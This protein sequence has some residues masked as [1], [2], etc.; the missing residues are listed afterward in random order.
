M[1]RVLG[2]ISALALTACSTVRVEENRIETVVLDASETV[3][4][5]GRRHA[6][7]YNTEIDLVECVSNGLARGGPLVVSERELT[8][9]LYPWLEPRIAPVKIE[10]MLHMMNRP[11][12]KEQ[13]QALN[14][15]YL[16]WVDGST[17]TTDQ[18]GSMSC[19]IAPGFA[20][21]YGMGVWTN[22]SGYEISIW[23]VDQLREI[24]Q[25]SVT[26]EGTS[27]LPA[28]VVP[29]PLIAR[30]QSS[31]CSGISNQ[32]KAYFRGEGGETPN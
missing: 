20:G 22:E 9:L 7:N 2:C 3:A 21:C 28:I 13:L 27:Y 11:K 1:K 14:L 31:A 15:K 12:V 25:I 18:S 26:A 24:D 29:V 8:D 6:S 5:L 32:V 19:A 10:G 30:V 23:N 17:E 4:V 16:V